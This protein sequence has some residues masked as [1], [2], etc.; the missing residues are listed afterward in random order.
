M[1][2]IKTKKNTPELPLIGDVDDWE[3][4]T[5]KA[6]LETA[7]GGEVVFYLDSSGGSVYGALAV[8]NLMKIRRLKATAVVIGE[9]SSA[10]LLIFG[11]ARRR[12]VAPAATLLFHKMRWQSE[13]H[14][15]SEEARQ[16]SHHFDKLEADLE[17]LQ[18][19]LFGEHAHLV[20]KW[21][22]E[23]RYLT[24]EEIAKT[25]LAELVEI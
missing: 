25:G 24:G 23:G 16:W 2:K 18:A 10:A 15:D 17:K 9:C 19:R 6:L 4:D 7:E 1:T 8:L 22:L 14:I 20:K 12:L 3:S 5:I 13:K 11:A 21:S